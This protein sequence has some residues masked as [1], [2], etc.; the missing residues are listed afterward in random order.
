MK[1]QTQFYP[2]QVRPSVIVAIAT[3]ASL[4]A[5]LPNQT[6]AQIVPDTT[7]PQNS[8]VTVNGNTLDINGGTIAGDNLFHSF[9]QFSVPTGSEAVFNN[10]LAVENI[11]SRVTGGR[12]SSIDGLIRA[13]GRANL[14]LL[15]PNGILFGPNAAL[16]IGGSFVGSTAES[17]HFSDGRTFDTTAPQTNSSLLSVSVPLGLQYGANPGQ[18][19]V[20]GSGNNVF[21]DG[22][23]VIRVFRPDGLRVADGQTLALLGGNVAIAGGNLTA[24][25]GRIELGSLGGESFIELVAT[26][27]GFRV[28]YDGISQF[29][30]IA[31]S[32]AASVETSGN[33]GGAIAVRGRR[34]TLTDG[35]TLL[36][37]TLGNGDGGTLQ[38]TASESLE[39]R[40]T[41]RFTPPPTETETFPEFFFSTRLSTDV[42][43]FPDSTGRG[44]TVAIETD[45]LVVADGAQISSGT[46][47]AGNAGQLK[48]TARDILLSGGARGIGPSGLFVPVAP[49]AS[50]NGGTLIVETHRL[51][52]DNG[53]RI[54]GST[55]GLGDAGTVT[56]QADEI[57]LE[58]TSPSGSSSGAFVNVE[59]GAEGNGGNI[60]VETDRLR[61]A[62][63]AQIAT[64]TFGD[65]N[66]GT[67]TA[68]APEI[69]LNET[70]ADG[71]L[72]SGLLTNVEPG[73]SGRGGNII[74]EAD[75]LYVTNGAQIAATTRSS[76]NAG[77]VLV[78]AGDIALSRTSADGRL[79]SGL[80]SNVAAEATGNGGNIIVEADRLRVTDGAQI[81][82]L[83]FG[84][85][86]AGELAVRA[87]NTE[88]VG[89]SPNGFPSSFLAAVE[90]GATGD[91]GNL[92]VESDRLRLVG[93]AQIAVSTEDVGNS[94][95]LTV[96]ANEIEAIGTSEFGRSGFFASAIAGTGNGGNLNVT[97]DS[98]R[99]AEGA[100]VSA[101]NFQSQNLA[102]PGRGAAGNVRIDAPNL[103]LQDGAVITAEANAGDRGNIFIQS[104]DLRMRRNSQMTTNAR[105]TATGG[106]IE[107]ETNTL[108]ALDNSDI[109]ANAIAN[110]GGRVAI[111]ADAIFG[112]E[113]RD[114]QTSES[115]IT[116]SSELG[117]AFSG[118]VQI[119]TPDADTTVGLVQLP[120]SVVDVNNL[121]AR[122]CPID[123]GS[124]F[125]V[126][127]RGGLPPAPQDGISTDLGWQDWR[128]L[129][130]LSQQLDP[131]ETEPGRPLDAS[132]IEPLIEATGSITTADGTVMLVADPPS[133]PS[134]RFG[135]S[136][137]SCY[138]R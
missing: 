68:I 85:G 10:S 39:L 27:P 29:Q 69:E 76:G 62:D 53:A 92:R 44:G 70:S 6:A 105:G 122:R 135:S 104:E 58:G 14:F 34:I 17:L 22:P 5:T 33:S 61:V 38:I 126:T 107:I 113:F 136:P 73:A 82:T 77:T 121:I 138:V 24:A 52:I 131:R 28:K 137:Q 21:L 16:N 130:R 7:L 78:T 71:R 63:G 3:T 2:T 120:D 75:R 57:N 102:P 91:G 94:G 133:S 54:L 106:N 42:G 12:V 74:V 116:A 47:S 15:N 89:T 114:S 118:I 96:R 32:E 119:K 101:S 115:D 9:E 50:G 19:D 125:H 30:D 81:A 129:E 117:P 86:N 97:A 95:T 87:T 99:L 1:P 36:A 11:I 60:T 72:P 37:D 13:N 79:P 8:R 98:L 40:G 123:R 55:F 112:I 64:L 67:I 110:F 56:L 18:I 51:Q 35:S 48:V 46:F 65:G 41:S 88:L 132:E 43:R 45:R 108:V 124:E 111:R 4:F 109:T 20:R 83:T 90:G 84:V 128:D 93:G 127:G 49:E 26:N 80:F 134:P 23:F 66:A 25:D 100:I 59:E 103:R 31:L